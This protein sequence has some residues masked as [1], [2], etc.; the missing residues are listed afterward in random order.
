MRTL[1]L[2]P[3]MDGYEALFDPLRECTPA[4]ARTI[5]M[6]YPPGER[7]SYEDLLPVVRAAL[8]ADTPFYLLGWSFAGPLALMAA[9]ERPAGLRGV[10]LAASFIRRPLPLPGWLSHLARPTLFKL[11][12][13]SFQVRALLGKERAP[14][15]RERLAEG[16]RRAGTV[17]LACRARAAMTVDVRR[18]LQSCPV[19]VLYLRATEDC[20]I[21]AR[22]A[23]EARVLFP[24][25]QIA[26]VP[27]P[28]L[29]LVT[30]P[31]QSWAALTS[32]M[33]RV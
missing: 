13:L 23:D 14:H 11:T 18:L 16:H 33:S 12:P 1:V 2:L 15:L 8:P 32:F 20:V 31:G 17:A 4:G 10:I 30:S 24:S 19:P 21:S 25:L 7:N 26:E 9:A 27:G 6:S 5:S 22:Q 28:H 3:G 29:A